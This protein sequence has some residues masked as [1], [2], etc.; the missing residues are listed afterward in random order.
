MTDRHH[1]PQVTLETWIETQFAPECRPHINTVR[2]WAA[3]HRIQPE[4]VKCG[5]SYYV[6]PAARYTDPNT[7]PKTRLIDRVRATQTAQP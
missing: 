3:T 4:P 1:N 5:R 6:D 7:P 2:R